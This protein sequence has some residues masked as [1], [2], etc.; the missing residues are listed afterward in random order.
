MEYEYNGSPLEEARRIVADC[1]DGAGTL[2]GDSLVH[3]ISDVILALYRAQGRSVQ[4]L[5]MTPRSLI[6]RLTIP[7]ACRLDAEYRISPPMRAAVTLPVHADG[8]DTGI[9]VYVAVGAF[10]PAVREDGDV[11]NADIMRAVAVRI[12]EALR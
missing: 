12:R 4:Y 1:R 6:E 9:A 5:N 8:K 3:A 2:Q 10:A 7:Q 11:S